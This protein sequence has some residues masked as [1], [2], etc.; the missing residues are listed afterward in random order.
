MTL[1]AQNYFIWHADIYIA[2][3]NDTNLLFTM[4]VDGQ[5]TMSTDSI[6]ITEQRGQ[7]EWDTSPWILHH[8]AKKVLLYK[9]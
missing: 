8:G 9:Y 3:S 4:D 6:D 2:G 5:S 7:Q 1:Q